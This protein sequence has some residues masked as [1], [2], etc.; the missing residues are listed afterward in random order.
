MTDKRAS[1]TI[2]LAIAFLLGLALLVS[3][4]SS[5]EVKSTSVTPVIQGDPSLP[6]DQLMDVG[7]ELFDPGVDEIDEDDMSVYPEVRRAEARYIPYRLMETMQSSANWGA[8]RVSPKDIGSTDINVSGKILR[9]D[10]EGMELDI[11]VSDATGLQW[12]SKTYSAKVGKYSY[13]ASSRANNDP[14]QDLYN[15]IANDIAVYRNRLSAGEIKTIRTVAELRFAQDFSPDA[16][17]GHLQTGRNG[18]QTIN[19]LPAENDPMMERINKIRERDYLFVDTLQDY[20]GSF[21][22]EMESP[23]HEWR[24][25]SY[26]EVIAYEELRSKSRMRA[27]AGVAAILAGIFAAGSN[28]G[29]ANAAAN[30]AIIGGGFLIKDAMNKH[31]ES[32]I[33]A[34]A[35]QELGASLGAE[36]T[37][38]VIELDD[39]T[40]TL[41]GTASNQYEQ[42]R[43]ILRDIYASEVGDVSIKPADTDS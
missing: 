36:I 23:Y 22:R 28:D 6:E 29:S 17:G 42:W 16:F 10:G 21:V 39:R 40:V 26:E 33:H 41:S 43:T 30:V 20:Y 27:A 1:I 12:Y 18:I 8:V 34:E 35:L 11:T 19:R 5:T 37:P 3:G 2:R 32:Q 13:S 38:Q 24:K 14:F 25:R 4:C 15:R 31:A 7:I 9:S